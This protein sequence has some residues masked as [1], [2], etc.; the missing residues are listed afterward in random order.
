[1]AVNAPWTDER[2]AILTRMWKAGEPASAIAAYLRGVSRS[3]VL[4]KIKR[5]GLEREA[6]APAR[7]AGAEPAPPPIAPAP[8]RPVPKPAAR[9]ASRPRPCR[10]PEGDPRDPAFRFCGEAAREGSP[11]CAAHHARAYQ[12]MPARRSPASK[13]D[14]ELAEYVARKL[15]ERAA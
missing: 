15:A 13:A 10:W 8:P 7:P 14:A 9:K 3:A 6:S 4:G 2:V 12:P 11:Y 5:L 1:M